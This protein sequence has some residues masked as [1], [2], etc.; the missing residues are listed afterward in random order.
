MP[1]LFTAFRSNL[2]VQ[3]EI[4]MILAF[5][6][7][8]QAVA[9]SCLARGFPRVALGTFVSS[10]TWVSTRCSGKTL[11]SRHRG[12][13]LKSRRLFD[14]GFA[15]RWKRRYAAGSATLRRLHSL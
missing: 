10:R 11:L 1:R 8:K 2:P 7:F 15:L 14:A 3:S 12:A 5:C 13:V 9:L 4:E 6:W